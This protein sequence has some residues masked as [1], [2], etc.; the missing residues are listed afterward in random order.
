VTTEIVR[1]GRRPVL[2]NLDESYQPLVS[3]SPQLKCIGI[4]AV[5]RGFKEKVAV[6]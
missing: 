6:N 5:A 1:I 3:V 2:S 4:E